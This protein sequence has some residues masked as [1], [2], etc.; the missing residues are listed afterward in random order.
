MSSYTDGEIR[1]GSGGGFELTAEPTTL[2]LGDCV[3]VRLTD[4][5]DEKQT[6]G[7]KEKYDIHRETDD[8]WQPVLFT[9]RPWYEDL[10]MQHDP[11]EGFVWRRRLTQA[12]LSVEGD[13]HAACEPLQSGTYRFLYWGGA[14]EFDALGVEFE[15]RE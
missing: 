15:V 12:G 14:G 10:G 5:S 11:G 8:G 3:T 9:K 13:K 6:T 7:I 4:R 1:W 2:A